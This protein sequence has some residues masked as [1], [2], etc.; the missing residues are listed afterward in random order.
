[1]MARPKKTVKKPETKIYNN[2]SE[3]KIIETC[4]KTKMPVLLQ[5]ETGTGKTTIVKSLAEKNGKQMVRINLNGQTGREELLG[6][7]VLEE[8]QLVW[9][10]G[11]LLDALKKGQWILLDEINAALPE[12]LLVLQA[13][14]ELREEQLGNV[15]LVEKD[16]E[17][18]TP[19]PDCRIFA[20]C[21]PIDYAGTKEFNAAT[22]SRFI[23]VDIKPLSEPD[24]VNL[25]IEKHGID[26]TLANKLVN[27]ASIVREQKRQELLSFYTSTRDLEQAA[28][29]IKDGIDDA[30]ALTITILN[31][32]PNPVEKKLLEEKLRDHLSKPASSFINYEQL[33]KDNKSL[34]KEVDNLKARLSDFSKLQE[35]MQ[36]LIQKLS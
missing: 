9:Q 8:G 7:Y 10:D 15:V 27:I 31:K 24:E 26:R 34:K 16:G 14:L 32:A 28:T 13:L 1:M 3:V 30:L 23:V 5:G 4:I 11:L 18:V 22:L 21:N 17:E 35:N 36:S 29:L 19:H 6:K 25:L 33:Q 2:V 12:V 20:T